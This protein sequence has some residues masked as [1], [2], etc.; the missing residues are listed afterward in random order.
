MIVR[1]ELQA[2]RSN[3]APQ[4]QAQAAVRDTYEAWRAGPGG[5]AE[6]ELTR[7]ADGA[8]L[9]DLP[10]LSALFAEGDGAADRFVGDLLARLLARLAA[11]PLTQSPLR[12]SSDDAVT[13]LVVARQGTAIL[14]L[15][16]FDGQALAARPA[17]VS[18][19]F[20]PTETF[21]KI[22][23]GSGEALRVILRPGD[24]GRA[25]LSQEPVVISAGEVA[26]RLGQREARVLRRIDGAM[27]SLRL[28]RRSAAGEIVR[29]YAL[30]DGTLLHQAAGSPRD[31]RLELAAALLGRMGRSDAAPLLAAMAEEQGSP[32]LRW[33]ALRECL[34]LDSGAGFAA[35]CRIAGAS[36]DPLAVPAGAL[37]AQLLEA[38]PQLSGLCPCPA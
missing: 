32:A 7:F 10:L 20:P 35:L 26:C 6:A 8:A 21:E 18:V 5:Q 37:R 2:L 9:D 24:D 22:L 16:L 3:D 30:A 34:A 33:Q 31:S 12:F 11:D 15:H 29:E 27:V 13:T 38:H 17:P 36:A 1:P 19:S 25:C 28:Q 14:T 4:R 23:R